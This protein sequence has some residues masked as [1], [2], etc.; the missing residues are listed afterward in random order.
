MG[1]FLYLTYGYVQTLHLQYVY[2]LGW[3]PGKKASMLSPLIFQ[4]SVRFFHDF[5]IIFKLFRDF[6]IR[7]QIL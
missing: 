5:I 7:C 1:I 2:I 4:P 6:F 3:K